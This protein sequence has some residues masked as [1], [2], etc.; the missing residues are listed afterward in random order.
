MKMKIR[1]YKSGI[2][3]NDEDECILH[4]SERPQEPITR[5]ESL[6]NGKFELGDMVYYIQPGTLHKIKQSCIKQFIW[7]GSRFITR[8]NVLLSNDVTVVHDNIFHT[9]DEAR[10]RAI[11]KLSLHLRVARNRLAKLQHD[12]SANEHL[13]A[14]LNENKNKP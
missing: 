4:D 1:K 5:I 9:I 12:I 7:H 8:Y 2:R 6:L 13:L 14:K 11:A 10:S 3:V